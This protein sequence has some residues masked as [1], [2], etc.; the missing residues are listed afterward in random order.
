MI[1]MIHEKGLIRSQACYGVDTNYLLVLVTV[2]DEDV[3][4][5]YCGSCS[6][7]I[8]DANRN[9]RSGYLGVDIFCD[10]KKDDKPNKL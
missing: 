5:N 10:L 1:L 2:F 3:E 6:I 9:E 7:T 4:D 8:H